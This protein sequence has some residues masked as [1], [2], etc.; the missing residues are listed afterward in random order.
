MRVV[1]DKAK[2]EFQA[3]KQWLKEHK[4]HPS[5]CGVKDCHCICDDW[6]G[7][8]GVCIGIQTDSDANPDIVVFCCSYHNPETNSP[9]GHRFLWHPQEANWISTLLSLASVEAWGLMPQYRVLMGS[10]KRK[11]TRGTGSHKTGRDESGI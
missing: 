1:T 11:R 2:I 8:Y 10:L 5:S 4:A 3:T 6:H 9:V 7:D